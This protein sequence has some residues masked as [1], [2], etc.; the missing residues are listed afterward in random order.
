MENL[1]LIIPCYNEENTLE[2]CIQRIMELKN[3]NI[4]LELIIVDDCSKDNSLN[5][6]YNLE[7]RYPEVKVLK[8]EVNMGKGAALRTGFLS[9]TG[10]Y[11]GVQDADVEYNPIDY[12]K[13]LEPL[14]NGVADVVYGSRYLQPETR[15]I[16]YFWHTC[17]NKF[18][19]FFSNMFTDLGITDMETCYKLFKK[20]VI[21]KLA[22]QFKEN[23]FGFEPEIT[24]L[25]SE[26]KCRVYECAISYNPRSYEEGKK[27]GWLDG[28]RAIYCIL[29]YGAYRAPLPMHILLYFIINS[30][31]ALTNIITFSVLINYC[32][33]LY[34]IIIALALAALCNYLLCIILIF[35]HLS[36]WWK[37]YIELLVYIACVAVVCLLD[38][39]FTS[40]FINCG[41]NNII[42]KS[43]SIGLCFCFN[44]LFRRFIV[45][46]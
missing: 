17:M 18:L 34:T 37:G 31:S 30:L 7:K 12:L 46:K 19:T 35:K 32:E 16:L 5:I 29:H 44:Y 14:K 22:P 24:A 9:A 6:A 15:R 28:L 21:Q 45:F 42:A 11:V 36:R 41:V 38:I 20:D 4:N 8:H 33:F 2:Q 25:I 23:R 1:S 13:L 40:F 3:H 27:I 43:I 10:D 39:L 26:N